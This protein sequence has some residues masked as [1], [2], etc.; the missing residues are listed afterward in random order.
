MA[1]I[2]VFVNNWDVDAAN[3]VVYITDEVAIT[4]EKSGVLAPCDLLSITVR[5]NQDDA[6]GPANLLGILVQWEIDSTI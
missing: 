2:D 4:P 5:R 6:S 1:Y 3:D